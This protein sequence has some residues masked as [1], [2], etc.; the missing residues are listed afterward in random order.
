MRIKFHGGRGSFPV[1][2]S[3]ARL[4]EISHNIFEWTRKKNWQN[5][6]ECEA[7]LINEMPRS[8]YQ[9]YGSHTTCI[10]LKVP[11]EI[12]LFFDCGSG[13]TA[14][15][16]DPQS[17]LNN[18]DFKRTRG[19]AA[20]F[21]THTHWDHISG[22]PSVSQIFET[23][24]EFH[25][26]GVHK[27]LSERLALLFEDDYFPVPYRMVQKNFRFHQ[28]PLGEEVKVG[29]LSVQHFAQSHPGGSFAYRIEDG[30]K[31]FVF[32]TD[33]ELKN[34]EAPHM[35]PGANTYSD[36]DLLVLDAHFSPEDMAISEGWGHASVEMAVDLA[37]RERAK[38]LCLFHQSPSYTDLQIDQQLEKATKHLK[39][40][41]SQSGMQIVMMIEGSEF[42]V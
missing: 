9:I 3:P 24:N 28:I 6:D 2:V 17:A 22:L 21:L 36:A 35:Q 40:K 26:Y 12:P 7:A 29:G 39:K 10:E 4:R 1:S 37:I 13:I 27:K 8:F 34:I 14:A 5:W 15:S 33:T 16:A 18:A 20:I 32:A 11:G 41:Y 38:K 30:K 23:G 42:E 25:F 31:V 19:K